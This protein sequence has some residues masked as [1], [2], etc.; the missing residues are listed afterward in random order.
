MADVRLTVTGDTKLLEKEIKKALK[1]GYSLGSLNTRGFS[2][3]LGKIK[4]QL[5]EFEKSLE[6]SNA[7][8][9]AFG[10]STGAILAVSTALKGMVTSAVQVEKA[11]TDINTILGASAGNLA[12]FGDKLFTIANNTGQSFQVV[13]E[14]ANEFARQGLG[15]EQTLARTNDALILTRISGMKAADSVA[16]LTAVMNGF[17]KSAYQSSEI[18]SKLAAV[19]AAFAVSSADLAE[20]LRRVG[21][22]AATAGVSLEELL[23]IVAATQQ[24]TARGGAVI[25]NSFKTIF[26]RVQ[27]PKVIEA[28]KK[29]GVE[30]TNQQ[31]AQ[32]GLMRILSNLAKTYD[33]LGSK[34]Q[35]LVAEMVGG[36]FQVNVLKAALGDLGK[37]Y[38][39]YAN[40]VKIAN[41]ASNEAD[42]RNKQLNQTLS[43]Q[44]I[45]TLNNLV[46]AGSAVGKLTF[47]PAIEGA[48]KSVNSLLGGLGGDDPSKM[49]SMGQK[50]AKGVLSGFGAVLKGPGIALLTLGLFKMFERL[51]KFTSDA[52][53]STLGFNRAGRESANIQAQIAA[54]LQKNPQI[55]AAI[56]SGLK[57]EKDLHT[58]ILAQIRAEQQGMVQIDRIAGS[59]ATKMAKSGY[60]VSDKG[61]ITSS[62][63]RM[64]AGV[65]GYSRGYVPTLSD[66]RFEESSARSLGADAGV[67]ARFLPNVKAGGSK[68]IIANN[69]EEIITPKQ[70]AKNYGVIPKGGESAIIP[71]YGSVGK[72]RKAELKRNL[73]RATKNSFSE[74]SIPNFVTI[75]DVSKWKQAN[76]GAPRKFG[77]KKGAKKAQDTRPSAANMLEFL[78]QNINSLPDEKIKQY[79]NLITTGVIRGNWPRSADKAPTPATMT[80]LYEISGGQV[81]T[82]AA[83]GRKK[84]ERIRT[85]LAS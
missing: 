60:K 46:K 28:L 76:A 7:R 12:K 17:N 66:K 39:L 32:L 36:V 70:F 47:G 1:S 35:A 84:D 18:T 85:P 26:T 82:S 30:T 63:S 29:L 69:K 65:G 57:T 24:I 6:A 64:S 15:M 49:E 25:G 16:A 9:I 38:S 67:K 4:G 3:P 2:Q 58:Q 44:L 27:R 41:S 55:L 56:N 34:Q 83:A 14:A 53:G 23:G 42:Q 22:T 59:I 81:G 61:S 37:E 31:G 62:S 10:A 5:G 45:V 48:L 33:T 50:M 20:A 68:G 77:K 52:L 80:R 21:S 19:D 79:S 51:T 72:K 13:A 40:A 73:S 54:H 11:L 71:K 78:G 8:V 74:G 43:S 75:E